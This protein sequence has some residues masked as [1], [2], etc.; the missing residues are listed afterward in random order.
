MLTAIIQAMVAEIVNVA[1]RRR[2]TYFFLPPLA[3]LAEYILPGIDRP[4]GGA[5]ADGTVLGSPA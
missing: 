2:A 3:G 1:N 4:A 5:V